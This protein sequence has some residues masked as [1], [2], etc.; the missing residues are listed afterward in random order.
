MA[1]DPAFLFYSADF[2]TGTMLM[3]AEQTGKYIRLL[4]LEHQ[5]G[6]LSEQDMLKICGTYD[7]DIFSKFL[8]DGD[9][10]YYNERLEEEIDKRKA[11]SES[12]RKNRISH[13]KHMS[14]T[15][16]TYVE[17]MG[18]E[19]IYRDRDDIKEI[20]SYLNEIAGTKYKAN[21]K[22]TVS[23]IQARLKEGFTVEDFKTV[24]DKQ[25]EKWKGT[26]WEQYMRPQTL[27]GTKFESYL[28]ATTRQTSGN[29]FLDM[30][31]EEM[32]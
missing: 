23:H 26:E 27:F 5:H 19:N 4:C 14:N 32:G 8:Q 3:S 10:L 6:H 30:L 28:N 16:K 29:V 17:H 31:K 12:R 25:W 18:N 11:Y 20:I 9:G 2:L 21:S 13:E 24:T 22:T 15:C 1:K 7:K